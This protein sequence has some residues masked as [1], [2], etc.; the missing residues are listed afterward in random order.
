LPK[1]KEGKNYNPSGKDIFAM[2]ECPNCKRTDVSQIPKRLKQ[3]LPFFIQCDCGGFVMYQ[4][5]WFVEP[6][7]L[8]EIFMGWLTQDKEIIQALKNEL[9]DATGA[10]DPDGTMGD[11]NIMLKDPKIRAK[12]IDRVRDEENK[13]V[14]YQ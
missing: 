6:Y 5:A 3:N 8:S 1:S 12:I 7:T 13:K 14:M 11:A 9:K 10:L 2:Y 4:R